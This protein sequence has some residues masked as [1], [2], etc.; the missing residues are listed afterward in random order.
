[1]SNRLQLLRSRVVVVSV[2]EKAG[3]T[4][5]VRDIETN[6]SE[7]LMKHRKV[8]S[9]VETVAVSRARDSARQVPDDGPSGIRCIGGVTMFQARIRNVGTC[10]LDAKGANRAGNTCKVVSTEAR[11]RGGVTRSSAEAAVM[12]VERR[13][14][15]IGPWTLRQP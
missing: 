4:C 14:H 10:C 11:R 1:M 8:I 9:D 6:A 3:K 2:G 7:P 15:V 5:Q 13:G 12:A